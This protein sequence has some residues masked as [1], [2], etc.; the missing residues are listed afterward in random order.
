[1]ELLVNTRSLDNKNVWVL[2]ATSVVF[3][4]ILTVGMYVTTFLSEYDKQ[5]AVLIEQF[6]QSYSTYL[7]L[8][9]EYYYTV[10]RCG[11]VKGY[12]ADVPSNC[13]DENRFNRRISI[14]RRMLEAR[15]PD[16]LLTLIQSLFEELSVKNKAKE[17]KDATDSLT[18]C[19]T[20]EAKPKDFEAEMDKANKLYIELLQAMSKRRGLLSRIM[21]IKRE[22][23]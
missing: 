15:Q 18:R 7:S 3:P 22:G 12:V 8:A 13:E 11:H 16:G 21:R 10:C 4:L 14:K 5:N 20:C 19:L 9:D 23:E 2:I 17:L 1:M 6:S